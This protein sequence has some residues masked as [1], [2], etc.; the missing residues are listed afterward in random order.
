MSPKKTLTVQPEIPP[1]K[2]KVRGSANEA[3]NNAAGKNT[4][5]ETGFPLDI[6]ERKQADEALRESDVKFR[7]TFDIS[8]I[9]IV[10]VGLDKRFIRCNLAFA[11]SLGYG[12]EELVGKL[13]EDVTLPEDNHIGMAEMMAIMKGEIA[14]SQVHKRYLRKD[15]QVIWGEVTISMIRDAE[16]RAQ[17]FLAM[18]QDI[19]ER[20]QA[21]D[22]LQESE[23]KFKQLAAL[24]ILGVY[25]IQN[26]KFVY[27]NERFANLFGYEPYEIINTLGPKD[28]LHSDDIQNV[29]RRLEERMKGKIESG[30]LEYKC[31]TKSGSIFFA[32]VYSNPINYQGEIAVM[33]TLIDI[34]ER[35]QTDEAL[36]KSEARLRLVTD[37]MVDLIAQFDAQAFFQ[38]VSPSYEKILGY[39]AEDLIGKSAVDFLH[40]DERDEMI[41]TIDAMLRL[42]AG[43]IQF[44]FRHKDGSYRWIEST[45]SNLLNADGQIIG[46]T[47]GSRDITERKQA[48]DALLKSAELLKKTLFSLLDAVFIIDADTVEIVDCN[49]AAS[50]IFGYSRQEMLGQTTMF[51]H[52]DQA[53]LEEFRQHL[54]SD[55]EA[56]KDFMF[57]SE[58]KMKRKD[59]TVF[60]SEHSV[61]PLKNEQGR[62]TGWVSVVRDIT[63]RKQAEQALQ[64]SEARYAFIANNTNDVIW[65]MSLGTGKFT[66]VSPSVQKLRG[67]TPDEVMN[68][69]MADSLTPES[70]QKATA[71]IQERL[72]KRKP[73]DTS[74]Y[75]SI[76]LADQPCKDGSV[77]STEAVGTMVF[78]ENGA[79]VE[80]IGVSRDITE[81]KQAEQA[82]L[83]ANKH[84]AYAQSAARAGMWDWD[85]STGILNWS[86]EMF[87][88]FGFDPNTGSPTFDLWRSVL[89]PED[90]QKA[91][92]R[93][94]QAVLDHTPLVS[95]YRIVTPS[96]QL[97]WIGVQGDTSYAADGTLLRMS[98]IC[99]DITE[100][101]QAESKLSETQL[102]LSAVVE[103]TNDFVWSVDP[104][105]FGLLTFNKRLSDNFL[106][107]RGIHI[108]TGMTPE[109]LFPRPDF[110]EVWD[111]LYRRAL[112]EGSYKT[113]YVGKTR[114]QIMDLNFNL[115]NRD[116]AI[117]GI[118]VFG[119]D[120]TERKQTEQKLK[121]YSEHLEEM[122]S[123]RTRELTEAQGKLIRQ[124]RLAVLGQLAGGVSH[125]LRNPL[126]VINNAIYYLKMVQPDAND[127]IQQYHAMI[128]QE[129]HNAEKIINDMLDF[130]RGIPADRERVAVPALVQGVLEQR[131]VP[132]SVQ[133]ALE[134][135]AD[136]PAVYID[137]HQMRQVLG[138]L[139]VN[140]C[141]AMPKGGKLFITA[142]PHMKM[143]SISVKDTGTGISPENMPKLFEPLFTTKVR[144]IGLGLAVSKKLTEANGGRI[145]VES[146]QGVG[147]TF[148]VYLPAQEDEQ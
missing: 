4:L 110:V 81:R 83:N 25:L 16:G 29:T 142:H 117:I 86:P 143:V 1:A 52:V 24:S 71:L 6:S 62:R 138:N 47:M 5:P 108:T 130:V 44:R 13:I 45:G 91:E 17:Y 3:N 85:M 36:R 95:E 19:T 125:E 34:T 60:I 104:E 39:R 64:K 136:L 7:Q 96:G 42:G 73:G 28:V 107:T 120:I 14:Q 56:G 78:D 124:E 37:N 79:P 119:R 40:P 72:A 129:V 127:K 128:E 92:E 139:V 10:M 93:I 141:Q 2:K 100:R 23:E 30:P 69:T 21:E 135:P 35:K 51:L 82:L 11:Q 26:G 48:Q 114:S 33:G 137:P 68:Q 31:V 74:S 18:I 94:N 65:T 98:G 113:E 59:G 131:P 109:D 38:Y 123:E 41:Q 134:L 126:G 50:A 144:G 121:E 20:K 75:S 140:A 9:G 8:P 112:L 15:G 46:S 102:L 70:L 147:T 105:R 106:E 55:M 87:K 54:I 22:A 115:L 90:R 103:S 32:E 67:Y 116:G 148:T 63:E 99:I 122:V 101:K 97:V 66:Y 80:I 57:L 111:T 27:V 43:A 89:H 118:S 132:P 53:S 61:V 145:E 84:L 76:T 88:L 49:P 58:Y 146:E 133:V 12:T 77:V